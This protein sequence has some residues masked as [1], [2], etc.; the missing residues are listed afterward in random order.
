MDERIRAK[1]DDRMLERLTAR[2]LDAIT[3]QTVPAYRALLT[4]MMHA[5]GGFR[6][7]ESPDGTRI[8]VSLPLLE[9]TYAELRGDGLN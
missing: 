2:I 6:Y 4:A 5:D 8:V 3:A 7:N 9:V 1:L